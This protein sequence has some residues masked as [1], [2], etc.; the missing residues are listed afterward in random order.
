MR[1]RISVKPHFVQDLAYV[2]EPE[3]DHLKFIDNNYYREHGIS[4]Y[5]FLGQTDALITDYSSVIFDYLLT[6]KPIGLT[7]ED[8]EEYREKT[9]FA[10]DMDMLCPC[11]EMLDTPEDFERFFR[12]LT[13]GND[14]H[15]EKREE[16][17]RLTNQYI[18]GN[19]TKRVVDWLES[20]LE[21]RA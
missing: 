15:R 18:D 7:W 3:L 13:E 9:G 12:D 14:P 6:G 4:A 2:Q 17:M 21:K 1:W 19:S 10:I 20:L 16:L 5:E 11:A 8:F